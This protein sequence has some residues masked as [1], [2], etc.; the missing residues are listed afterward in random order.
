M[1][2]IFTEKLS[3]RLQYVS[4]C[5]FNDIYKTPYQFTIDSVGFESYAGAKINYSNISI[6]NALQIK[7]HDLLFEEDIHTVDVDCFN[8]KNQKAFFKT[9]GDFAF[10]IFAASFYLLS[11]YEEYLP[12][13]LDEYGRF[14]ATNSLAYKNDFLQIPLVNIWLEDFINQLK[15]QFPYFVP[16]EPEFTD[17]ITFDIDSAFAFK[18]KGLARAVGGL[19]KHSSVN[20]LKTLWGLQ[21]DPFDIFD[22]LHSLH[23]EYE[24][25]P[26]FF[27]LVAEQNGEYDKHI[28]P[29]KPVMSRIIKNHAKHYNVGLHPSWRSNESKNIVADEIEVLED[30]VGNPVIKSRQHYIKMEL[31]KTYQNLVLLQIEDDF[32]MGYGSLNGFRASIASSVYWFDLSKNESTN[33]KLHPFC[34]MDA[35]SHYEQKQSPQ[36][37]FAELMAYRN[38]CKAL[39][40]PFTS[41]WHNSILSNMPEFAGW[42]EMYRAYLDEV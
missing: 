38:L 30:I 11:R 15:E 24:V 37:S 32:S 28:L 3:P 7:P 1:V 22:E 41:I 9:N 16:Q 35:N 19:I 25:K 6:P 21:R 26:T 10:D 13:E 8:W 18:H 27:F 14:D 20:R 12:H 5:F 4:D 36:E 39:K 34:F 2:W 40:I 31:P 33:L 42:M 23:K 29:F 17:Q